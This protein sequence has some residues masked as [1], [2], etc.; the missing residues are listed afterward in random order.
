MILQRRKAR[1]F[2]CCVKTSV[3]MDPVDLRTSPP[4]VPL[5]ILRQAQDGDSSTLLTVPEQG[6]RERSRPANGERG[7][8]KK[9]SVYFLLFVLCQ[10]LSSYGSCGMPVRALLWTKMTLFFRVPP[11]NC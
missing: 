8:G 3:P 4:F 1:S 7:R 2:L 10:D 6:R 5:S 9:V 11:K